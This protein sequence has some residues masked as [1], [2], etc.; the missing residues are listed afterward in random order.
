MQKTK[1]GNAEAEFPPQIC[2][3]TLPPNVR[4][5]PGAAQINVNNLGC[6]FRRCYPGHYVFHCERP[7]VVR[8]LLHMVMGDWEGLILRQGVGNGIRPGP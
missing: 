1:G 2:W 5:A 6:G 4:V 7:G 3:P 8:R